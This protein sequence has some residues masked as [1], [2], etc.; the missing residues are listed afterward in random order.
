MKQAGQKVLYAPWMDIPSVYVRCLDDRALPLF[1][2]E[3]WST[4]PGSK[5][6]IEAI[7]S[8]HSLFASKPAETVALIEN[9][10][11]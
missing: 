8:G 2:Q 9:Y 3:K 6:E 5:F 10:A 4:L 1:L 11:F 7:Q